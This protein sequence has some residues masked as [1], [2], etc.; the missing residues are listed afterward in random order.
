MPSLP[1]STLH[2]HPAMTRTTIQHFFATLLVLSMLLTLLV[3]YICISYEMSNQEEEAVR[4]I[5]HV[6]GDRRRKGRG[7]R[8]WGR[9]YGT[10][11]EA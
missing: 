5:L 4:I 1:I 3:A 7:G 2:P 6:H 11:G 8:D 9:G 10:F